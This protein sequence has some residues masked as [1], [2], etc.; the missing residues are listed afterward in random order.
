MIKTC[1]KTVSIWTFLRKITNILWTIKYAINEKN[2][3]LHP[4]KNQFRKWRKSVEKVFWMKISFNLFFK[5]RNEKKYYKTRRKCILKM[6]KTYYK[7]RS[8]WAFLRKMENL[9]LTIKYTVNEKMFI[10]MCAESVSKMKKKV[11][12]TCSEWKSTLNSFP[13][14]EIFKKKYKTRRKCMVIIIK[15][16]YKTRWIWTFLRKMKNTLLT[17]KYAINEKSFICILRK[18]SSKNEE[19]VQKTC[20]EWKST[21]F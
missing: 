14:F 18:I 5:F 10:F 6:I 12:K 3:Y 11:Q 16:F 7:R 19:K 4:A 9:L 15:I 1:Y 8:I 21:L 2:I 20:C 17:I 13:N